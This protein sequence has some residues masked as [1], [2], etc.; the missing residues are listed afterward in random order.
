MASTTD[1]LKWRMEELEKSGMSKALDDLFNNVTPIED[2]N[3]NDLKQE[4]KKN[5]CTCEPEK[6]ED[7]LQK[8]EILILCT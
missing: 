7:F 2:Q 4:V 5:M 3:M 8:V 1:T 6:L